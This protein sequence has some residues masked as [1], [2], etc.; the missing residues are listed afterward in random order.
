[1]TAAGI[2]LND[3]ATTSTQQA[4]LASFIQAAKDLKPN[5]S[6]YLITNTKGQTIAQSVQVVRDDV[7]K[8]PPLPTDTNAPT[9]FMPGSSQAKIELG[10]LSIVRAALVNSRP[11]SGVELLKSESLQRLGLAKQAEIGIRS[12]TTK[13]LSE[14]K[15]PYPEGTFD[16]DRGKV[17]LVL[18]SVHRLK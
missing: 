2:N 10:D 3:P 12:Q 9:Q 18:M 15:Q 1:M 16:V 8:Y 5:A 6:F 13:G 14:L 17:G 11:L 7:A 4:K